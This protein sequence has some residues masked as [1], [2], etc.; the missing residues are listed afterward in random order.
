MEPAPVLWSLYFAFPAQTLSA[1]IH[2]CPVLRTP[3]CASTAGVSERSPWALCRSRV[4]AEQGQV[5]SPQQQSQNHIF[6]TRAAQATAAEKGQPGPFPT[7]TQAGAACPALPVS[8]PWLLPAQPQVPQQLPWQSQPHQHGATC[9]QSSPTHPAEAQPAPPLS[10]VPVSL[11]ETAPQTEQQVTPV[12]TLSPA[13][14]G[15]ACA[16]PTP[17]S[18]LPGASPR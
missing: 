10:Y 13:Q 16:V 15:S 1:N 5:C 6:C 18:S 12:G 3:S 14:S 7:V 8:L 4:P 11:T 2:V 17:T 9:C